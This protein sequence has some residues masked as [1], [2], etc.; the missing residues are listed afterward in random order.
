MIKT[1][2]VSALETNHSKTYPIAYNRILYTTLKIKK[3][4]IFKEFPI[5]IFTIKSHS[6]L[7]L[8]FG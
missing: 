7:A 1:E 5:V 3:N 8:P 6:E 4:S 2:M